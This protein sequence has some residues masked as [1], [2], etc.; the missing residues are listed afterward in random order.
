MNLFP[1]SSSMKTLLPLLVVLLAMAS[2]LCA[3]T[4][5]A[6][7][8]AAVQKYPTLAEAGSPLNQRFLAL[9]AEKRKSEPAFFSRTDW[10]LRAADAAAKAIQAE[11]TAAKEKVKAAEEARLAALPP[12]ERVWEEDKARWVFERLIFGDGED[13]IVKKLNGSKVIGS[14]VSPS[15]RVALDQRYQWVLGESKFHMAFEMK[16]DHLQAFK[17]ECSPEK[18]TNLDGFV[19]DDW[20]RMRAAVVERFGEPS[21]SVAF[22]DD[23]KKLRV[24]GWL[25]TDSWEK[26][27]YRIKL[28]ITEDDGRC[29]AALRISDLKAPE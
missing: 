28:G 24:G 19:H 1:A 11:E 21:K 23:R 7:Q 2:S 14:R 4:V 22:P 25:V 20:T 18:T 12:D 6:S 15:M 3:Q 16:D 5:E 26:P 27:G 29:S 17:F 10:P 13:T 8:K 9:V